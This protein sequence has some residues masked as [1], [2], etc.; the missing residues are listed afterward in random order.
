MYHHYETPCIC[1]Q[2]RK[3]MAS[4]SSSSGLERRE[5]CLNSQQ[6][7]V[8]LHCYIT[9]VYDKS[10][11]DLDIKFKVPK[12]TPSYLTMLLLLVQPSSDQYIPITPLPHLRLYRKPQQLFL[13][14]ND[15]IPKIF[16]YHLASHQEHVS[17][18]IV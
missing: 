10:R 3:A 18:K 14:F 7:L 5:N 13:T 4:S 17:S 9:R 1:S 12:L 11:I 15:S 2:I 6:S 16:F 8:I